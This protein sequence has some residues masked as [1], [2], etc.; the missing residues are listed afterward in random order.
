V[1]R[2]AQEI[3]NFEGLFL[4]SFP[5]LIY[6]SDYLK[7]F[8]KKIYLVGGINDD[9]APIDD[10]LSL[11]KELTIIDKF[12]KVITTSHFYTGKEIEITDFIK[13]NVAP[14]K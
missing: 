9:I 8:N 13:E 11:Y 14:Q 12:L 6:K 2:A 7:T 3:E 10:L 1:S 4:V 5:F